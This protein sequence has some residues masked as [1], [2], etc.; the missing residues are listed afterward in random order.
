MLRQRP[1]RHGQEGSTV[2]VLAYNGFQLGPASRA[3]HLSPIGLTDSAVQA[4]LGFM[5]REPLVASLGGRERAESKLRGALYRPA[6]LPAIR[7]A[8][9]GSDESLLLE[10]VTADTLHHWEVWRGGHPVGSFVLAANVDLQDAADSTL[11]AV[12][13]GAATADTLLVA[14][15][16]QRVAR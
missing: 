1:E 3:L 14:T 10:R 12:T 9:A 6:H 7:R 4:W 8:I 15:L 2:D 13:S 5:L 11:W 16:R